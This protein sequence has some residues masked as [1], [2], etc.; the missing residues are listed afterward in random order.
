[1]GTPSP[2]YIR[3]DGERF[4]VKH[5]NGTEK[6]ITIDKFGNIITSV[7]MTDDHWRKR[8]DAIKQALAHLYTWT[9]FTIETEVLYLFNAIISKDIQNIE[10]T[11]PRTRTARTH[12]GY[13]RL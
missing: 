11:S 13:L 7:I 2:I 12:P 10:D 9:G 5:K 8:H 1:M 3:W 4:L 6:W